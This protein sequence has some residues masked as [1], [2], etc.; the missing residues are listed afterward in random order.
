MGGE[1]AADG[2]DRD[3][4]DREDFDRCDRGRTFAQC[5]GVYWHTHSRGCF[6]QQGAG[7]E[8]KTGEDV[9]AAGLQWNL[10][11]SGKA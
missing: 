2:E 8:G 11:V 4:S 1:A 10:H 5:C 9:S 6:R 3:V 7:N